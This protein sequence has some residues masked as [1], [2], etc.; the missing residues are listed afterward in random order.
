MREEYMQKQPKK[1]HRKAKAKAQ[2]EQKIPPRTTS[3]DDALPI[4]MESLYDRDPYGLNPI[5]GMDHGEGRV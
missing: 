1:R 5:F 4:S 2:Q 3:D